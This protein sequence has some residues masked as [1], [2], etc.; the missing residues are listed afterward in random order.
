MLLL[1]L[2]GCLVFLLIERYNGRFSSPSEVAFRWLSEA[3]VI[4]FFSSFL[5]PIVAVAYATSS[6]G[7]ERED[8]TLIY[9]LLRP[10]PRWGIFLAKFLAALPI[11]LL[12]SVGSLALYCMVARP[13]GWQALPVYV[14][15]VVELGIAYTAVFHFAAAMFRHA[16]VI[17]LIYTLFMESLIGNMPGIIKQI[18][19]NFYARSLMYR[20]GADYGLEMPAGEYFSPVSTQHA[21]L[22]LWGISGLA[23]A[24]GLFCFSQREYRDLT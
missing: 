4:G 14:P 24:A 9:L 3:F 8:R 5:V 6:L 13:V 22:A 17:A 18:T 20:A 21:H 23:L 11:V 12:V 1:P 7:A 19:L 15:A 16:T 2:G 10:I